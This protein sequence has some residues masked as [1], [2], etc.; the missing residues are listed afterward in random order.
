MYHSYALKSRTKSG[1]LRAAIFSKRL[2]ITGK[3]YGFGKT[4]G[5]YLRATVLKCT[6]TV[7]LLADVIESNYSYILT[8]SFLISVQD[9][10]TP[11]DMKH[12]LKNVSV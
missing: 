6:A 9:S 11:K 8:I 7:D 1:A 5:E 4:S 3:F 12:I 10:Q 2:L